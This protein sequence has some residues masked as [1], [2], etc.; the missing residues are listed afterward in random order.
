MMANNKLSQ[1]QG[2]GNLMSQKLLSLSQNYLKMKVGFYIQSPMFEN[3][4][5]SPTLEI[6][7]MCKKAPL[8]TIFTK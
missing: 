2:I 5:V 8:T 3:I 7:P 6:G 1:L 4:W